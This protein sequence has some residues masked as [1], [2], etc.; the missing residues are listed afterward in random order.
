MEV[1]GRKPLLPK[2]PKNK[3]QPFA[4]PPNSRRPAPNEL[5]DRV[6]GVGVIGPVD[7]WI[8]SVSRAQLCEGPDGCGAGAVER[9]V[10]RFRKV[11]WSRIGISARIE[12]QAGKIPATVEVPEKRL[13]G[14]LDCFNKSFYRLCTIQLGRLANHE[15][16]AE[17]VGD[18]PPDHSL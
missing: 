5:T 7:A 3:I 18:A 6:V 2:F 9:R 13:S 10:H 12:V 8:T 11:R 17:Q 14:P 4:I 1:V 15:K 16:A